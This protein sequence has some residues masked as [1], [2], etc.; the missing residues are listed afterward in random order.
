M[1]PARFETTHYQGFRCVAQI[2]IKAEFYKCDPTN[3]D[4]L[5]SNRRWDML[6]VGFYHANQAH[7][8]QKWRKALE[9]D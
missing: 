6:L 8:I 4:Y 9:G 7:D 2:W 3:C 5:N 1:E